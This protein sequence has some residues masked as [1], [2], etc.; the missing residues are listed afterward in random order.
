MIIPPNLTRFKR[1]FTLVEVMVTVAIVAILSAVAVPMYRDH[2]T[3]GRLAEAFAMLGSVQPTAEQFWSNN[4]TYVGLDGLN[5]FPRASQNFDFALSAADAASYR[6]TATG[7][8]PVQGFVFTIDQNGN[9]A[10]TAAPGGWT[11]NAGC[12]TDRKSGECIH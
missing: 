10:T 8:G 4:R 9:R 11:A 2:V 1:G 6:V 7:K 3:R 5:G 12:W